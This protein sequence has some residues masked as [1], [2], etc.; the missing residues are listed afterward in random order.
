MNVVVIGGDGFVGSHIARKFVREN[1]RV[2]VF[3][4]KVDQNLLADVETQIIREEGDITDWSTV[5]SALLSHRPDVAI[6]LAAFGAGKDGLAKSAQHS[7]KKALDVNINGFYNV[8]EACRLAGVKRVLWSGS[9]TV[10]GGAEEYGEEPVKE[11]AARNPSLFY[12]ATKAFAEMMSRYFRDVHQMEISCLRLPLLYGPGKW[13]KGAGAA[14]ADIFEGAFRDGE[15]VVLC[16]P[17]Q[18]DLMYVKDVAEL[19]Y[20]AAVH[21]GKLEET[22]NIVGHTHSIAEMAEYIKQLV[23]RYPVRLDVRRPAVVY[24]LMDAAK[25]RAEL[26]FVPKYTMEA[27]CKDYIQELGGMNS[28]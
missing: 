21:D 8:L 6:H 18:L 20:H 24:P 16:G 15:T 5:M 7:P 1:A 25:M 23:P 2:V 22:Y 17:E 27:A 19:F 28:D 26:G 14:L 13:Y 11:E 9:S 4:A 3:G 10:F 12:G